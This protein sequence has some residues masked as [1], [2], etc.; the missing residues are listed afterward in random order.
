MFDV[1]GATGIGNQVSLLRCD[2]CDHEWEEVLTFRYRRWNRA[3][4]IRTRTSSAGARAR[5][6]STPE[7]S[8]PTDR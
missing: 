5:M 1:V 4:E 6:S 8:E 3:A 2:N 7:S